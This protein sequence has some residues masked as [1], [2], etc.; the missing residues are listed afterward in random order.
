LS[1]SVYTTKASENSFLLFQGSY[2]ISVYL[3]V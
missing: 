1:S 3:S 2:A